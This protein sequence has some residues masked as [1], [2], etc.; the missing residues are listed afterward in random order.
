MGLDA[1]FDVFEELSL[2]FG[3]VRKRLRMSVAVDVFHPRELFVLY[4]VELFFKRHGARLHT[5]FVLSI[6]FGQRPVP[7][8]PVASRSAGEVVRLLR[9]AVQC[10]TGGSK[11]ASGACLLLQCFGELLAVVA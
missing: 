6:P 5:S 2:G 8:K 1:R 4:G 11:Q 3:Q 10:D 9:R 7:H